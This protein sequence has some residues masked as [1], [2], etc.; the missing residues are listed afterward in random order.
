MKNLKLPAQSIDTKLLKKK[1]KYL[2]EV[3]LK[4]YP[5]ILVGED[6]ADLILVRESVESTKQGPIASRTKLGWILHGNN[7]MLKSRVDSDSREVERVENLLEATTKR[8]GDRF[9]MGLL[10]KTDKIH[11]P[12]SKTNAFRKLRH[13]ERKMDSD[14]EYATKYSE[15]IEDYISKGYAKKL[16]TA[17]ANEY[18]F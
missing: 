7:A 4:S 10:W 11:L 15:K 3:D 18:E 17:E 8:V 13:V 16:T 1:W 2:E 6:N 5:T 12:E 14:S 9:Q